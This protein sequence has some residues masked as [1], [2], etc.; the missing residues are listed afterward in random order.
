MCI[1]VCAHTLVGVNLGMP[2]AVKGGLCCSGRVSLLFFLLCIPS[3]LTY[4]LL[5]ILLSLSLV[6]HWTTGII[7]TRT[8]FGFLLYEFSGSKNNIACWHSTYFYSLTHLPTRCVLNLYGKETIDLADECHLCLSSLILMDYSET[9]PFIQTIR[10]PI[11]LSQCTCLPRKFSIF[12]PL[13]M[14]QPI[15]KPA[16]HRATHPPHLYPS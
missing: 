7:D 6:S 8:V 4:Q 10:V 14:K 11:T 2:V 1:W 3:L 13:L 5:G 16:S 12:F 15:Q 9:Q